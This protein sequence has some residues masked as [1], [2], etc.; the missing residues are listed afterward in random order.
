MDLE[1][2][3]DAIDWYLDLASQSGVQTA[4]ISFLGQRTLLCRSAGLLPPDPWAFAQGFIQSARIL[5][6]NG[7][8]F[9]G[10]MISDLLARY[11]GS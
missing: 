6:S 8:W 2:V 9:V 11:A 7:S 3:R 1:L 10:N 4:Q 5:E